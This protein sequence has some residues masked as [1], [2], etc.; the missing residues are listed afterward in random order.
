MKRIVKPDVMEASGSLQLCA[1]QSS[2]V[3]AAIHSLRKIFIYAINKY[4]VLSRLFIVGGK[5]LKSSYQKEQRRVTHYRWPFM[6]FVC[7]LLLQVCTTRHLP[8]NVGL[9][10]ILVEQGLRRR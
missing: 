2:G 3:E 1:G 5:E 9:L 10:T 4:R 7:N 6:L 8:N